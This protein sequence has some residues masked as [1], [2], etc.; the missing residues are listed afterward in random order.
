MFHTYSPFLCVSNEN[1]INIQIYCV[2]IAN[3]LMAV[4]QKQLKRRWVFSNL[5]SFYK[6]DLLNE[7][8]NKLQ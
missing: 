3:F 8:F 1:A 7:V 5:V 4:I 2:L 6:I